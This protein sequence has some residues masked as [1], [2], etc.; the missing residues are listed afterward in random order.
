[1]PKKKKVAGSVIT[2]FP[3]QQCHVKEEYTEQWKH[4]K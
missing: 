4:F 2:N 1:M 3:Y